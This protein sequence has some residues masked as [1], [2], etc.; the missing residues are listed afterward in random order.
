[1]DRTLHSIAF[2]FNRAEAISDVR[3]K[4]RMRPE[5]LEPIISVRRYLYGSVLL[6]TSSNHSLGRQWQR[7][8]QTKHLIVHRTFTRF[9]SSNR[10]IT[11]R[12]AHLLIAPGG[13]HVQ[14]RLVALLYN[15]SFTSA[16]VPS[17]LRTVVRHPSE[18]WKHYVRR[19]R[20]GDS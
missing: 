7:L 3:S 2:Y 1:V 17:I 15:T 8:N 20:Q 5:R 13:R 10:T 14:L 11:S 4:V 6:V 9:S 16:Q 12:R 18:R 19:C